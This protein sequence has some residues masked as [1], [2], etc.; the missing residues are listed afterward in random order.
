MLGVHDVA[1]RWGCSPEHVR[2]L[3]ESGRIPAPVALGRL[4]RWPLSVLEQWEADSC[5]PVRKKDLSSR[6]EETTAVS[7]TKRRRK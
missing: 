5:P 7:E 3:A 6:Q 2:R 1:S 4:I